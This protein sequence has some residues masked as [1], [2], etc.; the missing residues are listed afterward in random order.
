MK[1]FDVDRALGNTPPCFT[2]GMQ[3]ALRACQDA[4]KAHRKRAPLALVLALAFLLLAG[5]ALAVATAAGGL[6]WF[7]TVSLGYWPKHYPD[8]YRRVLSNLQKDVPYENESPLVHVQ[9][10]DAA[11][12]EDE[13]FL[14]TLRATPKNGS[15]YEMYDEMAFLA[16]GEGEFRLQTEKGYDHPMLTMRD[17]EKQLI[18]LE[19][20]ELKI[21][22]PD[23][24]TLMA[25]CSYCVTTAEG[26]VLWYIEVDFARRQAD[27]LQESYAVYLADLTEDERRE[28]EAAFA[29]GESPWNGIMCR[30]ENARAAI[31]AAIAPD[32]TLSL[33]LPYFLDYLSWEQDAPEKNS[34][35]WDQPGGLLKLEIQ[36]QSGGVN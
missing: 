19:M 35:E 29:R 8:T 21:G 17:P 9:V 27:A 7:M 34:V 14:L 24:E 33:Y 23:G 10:E 16:D 28:E 22:A 13:I 15:R 6:E 36:T 31:R 2:E 30:A 4:P 18:L 25:D 12:L 32:G 20:G 5:T 1:E 11:W 3:R 26:E